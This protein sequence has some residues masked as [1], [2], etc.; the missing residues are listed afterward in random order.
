MPLKK[1]SIFQKEFRK[2]ISTALMAAFGLII[3]LAWK[4]V[5]TE[6]VNKIASLSPVHSALIIALIIT[7]ICVIGILLVQKV[8]SPKE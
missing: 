3:A 1:L 6:Y 4:D 8:L 5:I 2:A 7:L